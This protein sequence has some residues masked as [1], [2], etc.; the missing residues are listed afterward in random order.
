[1]NG[2]EKLTSEE[3]KKLDGILDELC[4]LTLKRREWIVVFNVL[5]SLS[6][7]LGDAPI[8]Q[9]IVDTVKPVATVDTNIKKEKVIIN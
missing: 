9:K 8:V 3:Q 7:K 4:T 6:Y 2:E 1:M 5:V